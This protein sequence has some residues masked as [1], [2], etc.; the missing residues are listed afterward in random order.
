[1]YLLI[2]WYGWDEV[3]ERLVIL[4]KRSNCVGVGRVNTSS[5]KVYACYLVARA[6]KE[7]TKLEPTPGSMPFSMN[8]HKVLPCHAHSGSVFG[9]QL[10]K[11]GGELF[12]W[13]PPGQLH[14]RCQFQMPNQAGRPVGFY[15]KWLSH[16]R[17]LHFRHVRWLKICYMMQEI[18]CGPA[19]FSPCIV[20]GVWPFS[21]MDELTYRRR[22]SLSLSRLLIAV[23]LL[24]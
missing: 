23:C 20:L 21:L 11:D 7:P 17:C 9:G 3:Q 14:L 6:L 1:M 16:R 5:S 15:F 8:K 2:L 24:Y 18:A 19:C 22:Y 4:L 13:Y 10:L 12:D